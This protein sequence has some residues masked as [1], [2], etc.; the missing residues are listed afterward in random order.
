M[1]YNKNRNTLKCIHCDSQFS[2]VDLVENSFLED[3]QLL[4]NEY[5]AR[6]NYLSHKPPRLQSV[7]VIF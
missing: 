4:W 7:S 3:N 2:E 5:T 6:D 1:Q